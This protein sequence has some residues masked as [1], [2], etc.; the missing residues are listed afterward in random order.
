ML[1][2]SIAVLILAWFAVALAAAHAILGRSPSQSVA[3]LRDAL[4]EMREELGR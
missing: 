4:A 2:A 1:D 3:H